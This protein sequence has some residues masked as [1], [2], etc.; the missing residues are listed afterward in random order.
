VDQD[1][2][3]QPWIA[4]RRRTQHE[5]SM[6]SRLVREWITPLAVDR[7]TRSGSSWTF[8]PWTFH[9]RLPT[10]PSIRAIGRT[11]HQETVNVYTKALRVVKICS[12]RARTDTPSF[13]TQQLCKLK[14][15]SCCGFRTKIKAEREV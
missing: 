13:S 4:A 5:N 12:A 3:A 6:E 8:H 2:W 9:P 1:G 11:V 14:E 7:A 15:R 10:G